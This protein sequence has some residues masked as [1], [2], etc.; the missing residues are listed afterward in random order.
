M[1]NK[2]R[3]N[4][5]GKIYVSS[6]NGGLFLKETSSKIKIWWAFQETI[7]EMVGNT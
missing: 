5:L 3:I 4:L 6:V 2:T 7:H 1:V